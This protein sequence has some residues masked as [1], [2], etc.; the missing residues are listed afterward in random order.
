MNPEFEGILKKGCGWLPQRTTFYISAVWVGCQISGIALA[1]G[2]ALSRG[3]IDSDVIKLLT[4]SPMLLGGGMFCAN[5]VVLGVAFGRFLRVENLSFRDW[6]IFAGTQAVF[7]VLSYT[8]SLEGWVAHT[9]TFA[10]WVGMMILLA[11]GTWFMRRWQLDQLS[12]EIEMIKSENSARRVRREM[13]GDLSVSLPAPE[14]S[15]NKHL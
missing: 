7:T 9:V 3:K 14:D 11:V 5:V 13:R 8:H 10:L 2:V 6:G 4:A 15:D 1:A 12:A